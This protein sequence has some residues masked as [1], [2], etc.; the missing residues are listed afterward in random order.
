M[1]SVSSV[2]WRSL[3]LITACRRLLPAVKAL[4][5][6]L[7][8]GAALR[9]AGA[10]TLRGSVV[11]PSGAA[12]PQAAVSIGDEEHHVAAATKTDASGH[13][14]LS[15]TPDPHRR[16]TAKVGASG[17]NSLENEPLSLPDG[18]ELS[19]DFVLT[20]GPLSQSVTVTADSRLSDGQIA[21][22]AQAGIL[23]TLNVYQTPFSTSSYTDKLI[24]D[25]Q[26]Q[27]VADVLSNDPSVRL[28]SNRYSENSSLIVRGFQVNNQALLNGIPGLVDSRS[29]GLDGIEQVE[30]YKGPS[31]LLN[32]ASSYAAPGGTVNMI[33]K[34]A[35]DIPI[36]DVTTGYS[37]N[38]NGEAHVDLGRRF[39]SEQTWGLRANIGGRLGGT[40]V[41]NQKEYFGNGSA[42]GDYR[43]DRLRAS[44]DGNFLARGLTAAIGGFSIVP[45]IAV[46]QAPEATNNIFDRSETFKKHTGNVLARANY[47]YSPSLT[48]DGA[49]GHSSGSE[50]YIGPY[51]P[52]IRNTAGDV[53]L[54]NIP[55][56]RSQDTDV[57]RLSGRALFSTGPFNHEFTAAGDLV[58]DRQ[59][60]YFTFLTLPGSATQVTYRT[61]IYRPVP[62][63]PLVD[64]VAPRTDIPLTQRSHRASLA[65]ADVIRVWNGRLI[66]IVGLRRQGL[67]S[68]SY[69][70]LNS[71]ITGH[72]DRAATTPAVAATYRITNRLSLYGNYVEDLQQG[73]TAPAGTVNA[74]QIFAPVVANQQEGGL[75]Y[76]FG[77]A[78]ATLSFYRITQPNSYV[79]GSSNTFVLQG[80]QRNRGFEANVFGSVLPSLRLLGG[81][82]TVEATQVQTG[83]A[84]LNGKRVIGV[85]SAQ[86]S[87]G[88][89]WTVPRLRA[90][91]I[92]ARALAASSQFAD[93]ANTQP[94]PAWARLD[95]GMRYSFE[96]WKYP[97]T[98]GVNIQNVTGNNYWES[99]FRGY[100]IVGA[101]RSLRVSVTTRF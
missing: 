42:G 24:R 98:F 90:L 51:S 85:P 11:D 31:T 93:A 9:A 83:N 36:L 54:P 61:N 71:A 80:L 91:A 57:V 10:V 72:Y 101:P 41:D 46:P 44:V 3:S 21:T 95:I 14:S 60:G 19:H 32:G 84:A 17:F 16:Y 49:Y 58:V 26:A 75:K 63:L 45:G 69:N 33:T 5:A 13:F 48:F 86:L 20:L 64:R 77:R 50:T 25:Q 6:A 97:T 40:P 73:P 4:C 35:G 7:T 67:V 96:E 37:S 82:S 1:T 76:D 99:A 81:F 78:G 38:S 27:T 34:R 8:L 28:S 56:F 53:T 23:G 29:P 2:E 55:Y 22:S 15:L 59:A 88:A 92:S 43:G 68:S 79:D 18:G 66:V 65:L 12:I 94:V 70:F 89:D 39:G 74:N 87:L 100:L 30:L 52:T 47:A 62:L